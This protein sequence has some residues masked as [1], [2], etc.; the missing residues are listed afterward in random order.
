MPILKP[1][2]R[3]DS[4]RVKVYAGNKKYRSVTGATKAEAIQK[5]EKLQAEL[6]AEK[7][8]KSDKP[9]DPY[10]ELTV[11]EAMERYVEAK[12]K[13][14]RQRPTVNTLRQEKTACNRS[15]ISN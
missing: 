11:A 8:N 15:M 1:E 6:L 4:W 5:A 9:D 13:H 2:K 12:R 10:A 14:F 7:E 3:G